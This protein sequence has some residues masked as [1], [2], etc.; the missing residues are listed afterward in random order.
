[1]DVYVRAGKVFSIL[2]YGKAKYLTSDSKA[3]LA[4]QFSETKNYDSLIN[5]KTFIHASRRIWNF[6]LIWSQS[7]C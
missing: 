5:P 3:N 7:A 1:M 2:F 4:V 6:I